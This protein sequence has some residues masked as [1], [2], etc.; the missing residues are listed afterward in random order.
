MVWTDCCKA[1][2]SSKYLNGAVNVGQPTGYYSLCNQ[3]GE[4]IL[5]HRMRVDKAPR[6]L[7]W[8]VTRSSC[9]LVLIVYKYAVSLMASFL[10][11][12]FWHLGSVSKDV[13]RYSWLC[14]YLSQF[15]A[16]C[17]DNRGKLVCIYSWCSSVLECWILQL[18]PLVQ[19]SWN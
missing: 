11:F 7:S 4:A 17:R 10:C 14:D 13:F 16:L 6:L 12:C 1:S 19:L 3:N 15:Y 5:K 8:H 9:K 2:V 18:D